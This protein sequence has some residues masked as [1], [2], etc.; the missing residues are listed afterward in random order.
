MADNAT[1]ED[2]KE[3]FTITAADEAAFYLVI[4]RQ[5]GAENVY[6]LNSACEGCPYWRGLRCVT[7]FRAYLRSRA[8]PDDG[9]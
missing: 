8:G 5:R 3:F 2:G 4:D 9:R 7:C 6:F 1:D